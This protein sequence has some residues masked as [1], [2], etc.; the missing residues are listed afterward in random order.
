MLSAQ[1][2]R[3]T[4]MTAKTPK[5]TAKTAKPKN[6]HRYGIGLML[7]A[8]LIIVFAMVSPKQEKTVKLEAT[9]TTKPQVTQTKPQPK[10]ETKQLEEQIA[11]PYQSVSEN[12]GSLESGK[13]ATTPGVNGQK[14]ITYEVTFTDDKETA[15]KVVNERVSLPPVNQVTRIGT[16]V[17]PKPTPAPAASNCNTNYSGCV[18]IASDVDCA[19]GSG[20]GPAYVSG[21]LQVI[22]SDV[23]RLDADHD[24]IACE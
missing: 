4:E 21:P 3:E 5:S 10:I 23:Y 9:G 11:I 15:R 2:Y 12:D 19:G 16:K 24:G 14:V 17:A 18:P 13:T 8:I 6:Q 22:G 1:I 20:D 7:F